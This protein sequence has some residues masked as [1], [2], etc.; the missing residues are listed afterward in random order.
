M[1]TGNCIA[2]LRYIHPSLCI[3]SPV[4]I[5]LLPNASL[6]VL[7]FLEFRLPVISLSKILAP[8]KFFSKLNPT[9]THTDILR[10]IAVPSDE[11]LADLGAACRAAIPSGIAL[12]QCPHITTNPEKRL[13]LWVILYWTEAS[14]LRK[15]HRSPW[16]EAEDCLRQRQ[17]RWKGNDPIASHQ[18]INQVYDTLGSLPWSGNIKGLSDKELIQAC[19]LCNPSLALNY[20]RKP[21][22]RS[23]PNRYQI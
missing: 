13:P 21:D 3:P 7:E 4:A 22:A 15:K 2:D 16:A 12:I 19:N 1:S 17:Q 8:A 6:S 18:L 11:T 20:S 23:P 5:E 10:G 14:N 9:I